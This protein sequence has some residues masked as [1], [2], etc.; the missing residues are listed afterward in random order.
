MKKPF[1]SSV[2]TVR[3]FGLVAGHLQAPDL[4]PAV[5]ILIAGA[6]VVAHQPGARRALRLDGHEVA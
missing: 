2:I 6:I 5:L 3:T 1:C 4:D